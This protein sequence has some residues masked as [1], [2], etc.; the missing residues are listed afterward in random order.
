[1]SIA[2]TSIKSIV[3]KLWGVPG[4]LLVAIITIGGLVQSGEYF[5][6]YLPSLTKWLNTNAIVSL[7][8]LVVFLG[9]SLGV[10]GWYCSVLH[11]KQKLIN[12]SG[13]VNKIVLFLSPSSGG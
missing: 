11:K 6:K 3:K 10:L 13:Q 4:A 7:T 2:I 5:V 9:C 8:T 1:M 12:N